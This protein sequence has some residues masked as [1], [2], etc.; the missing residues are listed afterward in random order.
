MPLPS[1]VRFA[2]VAA[3]CLAVA[4]CSGSASP[5]GELRGAPAIA[6]AD[7]NAAPRTLK[8]AAT[9][10]PLPTAA[11]QERLGS[12]D[13]SLAMQVEPASAAAA[14]S[15]IRELS[16]T[17]DATASGLIREPGAAP[18]EV[19]EP[20]PP[21]T[22]ATP[23]QNSFVPLAMPE[24]APPAN[25]FQ[26]P[27]LADR[28]TFDLPP[29]AHN[30]ETPLLATSPPAVAPQAGPYGLTNS[31][32]NPSSFTPL[33]IPP[34][35]FAPTQSPAE[36]PPFAAA[37]TVPAK[38][39][40]NSPAMQAVAEQAMLISDQ[41]LVMAQRGLLYSARAEL[42]KSLQLIAQALD[43]QEGS[44]VHAAALAAGLAALEEAGDFAIAA[45]R[46]GEATSIAATASG[47]R[48]PVVKNTST[49][50]ISP[51]VAQQEYFAF[52]QS[53][54]AI[55]AGGVPAA[56]QAL[57][58]LGRLHSGLATTSS[59]PQALH[60]PRAMVFH[61][62]ALT[63]DSTNYLA[64]NELGVLLARFGQL[65]DARRLLLQSVTTHP[66]VEGWHNLAVVHRRL[67]EADLA[68]RAEHERELVAKKADASPAGKT[69]DPVRWVD[70]KTFAASRGAATPWP[71]KSDKELAASSAGQRR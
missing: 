5:P 47:H 1:P 56:S 28:P 12:L 17:P 8:L 33:P 15:R 46:P 30:A 3:V 38:A 41:A 64:A 18:P 62:A 43:A 65:P 50:M 55:A 44:A 31:T 35:A 40:A 52:A 66:H 29:E 42:I 26:P 61:Q 14:A 24:T 25:S 2:A 36:P 51:V 59:D 22:V 71:E 9:I 68:K 4:G 23:R 27:Q 37:S 45:S 54:L 70:A 19:K 32:A 7:A 63:A 48:T 21:A 20:A 16:A 6:V 10:R 13:Q 49:A 60:A 53:H 57:Y 69:S 67:G 58:R 39:A 11:E 34:E